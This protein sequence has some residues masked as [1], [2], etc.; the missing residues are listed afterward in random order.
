ML[1]DRWV[2]IDELRAK[3]KFK[4]DGKKVL[5]SFLSYLP[6]DIGVLANPVSLDNDV[7]FIKLRD[8]Y[9][10]QGFKKIDPSGTTL[11]TNT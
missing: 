9:L 8:W 3:V 10:A 1:Y 11:M 6:A 4:G 7:S 2:S 5:K